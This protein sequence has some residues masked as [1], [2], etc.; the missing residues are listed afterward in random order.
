MVFELFSSRSPNHSTSNGRSGLDSKAMPPNKPPPSRPP[1]PSN[2]NATANG[3]DV[4]ETNGHHHHQHH[5]GSISNSSSAASNNNVGGGGGGGGGVPKSSSSHNIANPS[6]RQ[7]KAVR[8]LALKEGVSFSV[9]SNKWEFRTRSCVNGMLG[10][11]S[12][13]RAKIS[14]R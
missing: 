7:N 10:L 8:S 6:S 14:I 2:G 11:T 1:M 3:D 5:N 13:D 4:G 9:G 12:I